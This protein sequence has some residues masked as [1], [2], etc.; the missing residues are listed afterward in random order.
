MYIDYSKLWKL[1]I[2]KG[3]SKTDLAELSGISSRVIAKL[4]KNQTVTTDTVA[5]ICEVLECDVGDIMECASE[6]DLSLYDLFRKCAKAVSENDRIKTYELEADGQKYVI[7][8][9][10]MR[11]SKSSMIHCREDGCVYWQE[12]YPVGISPYIEEKLLIK[13]S[14]DPEV[15]EIVVIKG[16]PALI[17]GL[18]EGIFVSSRG[19]ARSKRYVYVMSETAFKIFKG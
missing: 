10:E 2:D 17:S 19:E 11:A 6:K 18:D 5:R 15:K 1:L 3:I 4:A 9:S 7:H 8:L 13:P 16:K 12:T 14:L